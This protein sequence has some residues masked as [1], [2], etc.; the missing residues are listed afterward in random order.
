MPKPV[1]LGPDGRVKKV[2]FYKPLTDTLWRNMRIVHLQYFVKVMPRFWRYILPRTERAP[3]VLKPDFPRPNKELSTRFNLDIMLDDA[4]V[5][6]SSSCIILPFT[7]NGI[8]YGVQFTQIGAPAK[9]V[10]SKII[11]K[12]NNLLG[13]FIYFEWTG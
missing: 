3:I 9:E 5:F 4:K 7:M 2:P 11:H 10:T 1:I 6:E 8:K 12:V 13:E